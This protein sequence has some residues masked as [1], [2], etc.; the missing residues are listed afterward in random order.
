MEQH[1]DKRFTP[2]GSRRDRLGKLEAMVEA[3]VQTGIGA[4]GL[5]RRAEASALDIRL[6]EIELPLAR[7]PAAFDGY[8]ILHLSDLH[9]DAHPALVD[10]LLAAAD[11]A[12]ADL[13]VL[14]GD[15]LFANGGTHD[16]IV[17]PV[18][19]LAATLAG[20]DGIVGVLGNHDTAALVP[21]FEEAGVA[22]LVNEGK[23]VMRSG[24]TLA[25]TGLDDVHRFYSDAA[26]A[27]LDALRPRADE[28]GIALVHSPEL[29]PE[30]AERGYSLYL[31]GHTH[32]GQICLPGGIPVLTHMDRRGG[33]VPRRLARGRWQLGELVGVTNLGAGFSG[34]AARLNAPP[35]VLRLT[36]RRHQPRSFS[37]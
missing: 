17:E 35:Q 29:A 20:P 34:V 12:P 19:R 22:C 24:A 32:G 13:V 15:Y 14:T 1:A 30:A 7:L 9:L 5:R 27:S 37:R 28:L 10:R 16:A 31:C 4:V 11:G 26:L 36:L 8:S 3:A 33:R 6:V 25:I 21:V 2:E 23:R 18:A